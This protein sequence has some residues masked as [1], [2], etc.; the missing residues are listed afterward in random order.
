MR[1]KKRLYLIIAIAIYA[2]FV[3]FPTYLFTNDPY[4]LKGIELGLR[5][6]YLVFIILFSFLT[7][8]AK[9][10]TGKTNWIN[11]FLLLPLFFVSFVN[12]FY[13]GIVAN[14]PVNNPF[15]AL[16]NNDGVVTL[17]VLKFLCIVVT[18]VEEELLFR[19]ILQR[20]LSVGHKLVRILITSA[21]F[22]VSHFFTMLY[23]GNGVII[24]ID[25]LEIVFYFG[26][27]IILG[28]LYEY[29]NNIV[30]S[31]T[32]SMIY[33]ICGE[34]I[35]VIKLSSLNMPEGYPYYITMA[36]FIVGA[37]AYILIFYFLMLK[38]ENR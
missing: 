17:E 33:S 34:M 31:I 32:F 3:T 23:A 27:G 35:Y 5:A 22:A 28:V 1:N 21:V 26:I 18:V 30:V 8:I 9:T 38:R 36:S 25:L 24:P 16:F 15:D 12:I 20:N 13:L 19:Y 2:L 14:V 29:T 4:V 11:I 37:I 6:S 10:Y 7:R